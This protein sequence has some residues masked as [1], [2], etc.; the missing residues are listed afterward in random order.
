MTYTW[1]GR[2]RLSS[3]KD[4]SGNT[5]SLVYDFGRNLL[6]LRHS[7]GTTTQQSFVVDGLTNVVS[8]TDTSGASVSLLTGRYLDSH[9]ASVDSSGDALFGIGDALGSSSAVANGPGTLTS[10][11]YY[12][13]FGQTTGVAPAAFPFAYRA[14][15]HYR[16]RLLLPQSILRRKPGTVH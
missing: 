7:S 3:I 13:P 11:L 14:R 9:Y 2:N 5:T 1:D 8:L 4:S 16:E 15:S 12:E 10:S 6:Q